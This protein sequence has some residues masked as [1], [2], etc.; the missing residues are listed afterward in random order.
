MNINTFFT[1]VMVILVGMVVAAL[2]AYYILAEFVTP[3]QSFNKP[4][5]E[6]FIAADNRADTTKVPTT[7]TDSQTLQGGTVGQAES[8]TGMLEAVNTGCFSDGECSITVDSKQIIALV[9]RSQETVGII[10]GVDGFGDLE[11]YV[12]KRVSIYARSLG[13][14]S[15]TLYG[16]ETFYIKPIEGNPFT[17]N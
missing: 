7:V 9:G 1:Y 3:Q 15:F 6:S 5:K 13:N 2:A 17:D 10:Q 4:I 11:K 16:D 14:N 12:G 8:F